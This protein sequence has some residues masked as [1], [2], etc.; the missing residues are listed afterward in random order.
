M[1]ERLHPIF[2]DILEAYHPPQLV[3][4]SECGKPCDIV[5][6]LDMSECCYAKTE[7]KEAD[8]D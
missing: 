4:C 2:K 6:D 1:N 5:H 8:H 7:I 3:H